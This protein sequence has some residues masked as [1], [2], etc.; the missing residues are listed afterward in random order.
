MGL[1]DIVIR[2]LRD[3]DMPA[4]TEWYVARKWRVPPSPNALPSTAYV[5][6]DS[7]MLL[8][9]VWLYLTNS[10]IAMVDWIAT[11]PASGAKGLISISKILKYIE[12]IID[13]RVTVLMHFT[14]NEKLSK[15]F[16][17]K[18][19]FTGAGKEYISIKTLRGNNG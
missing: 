13:D 11:N 18:C 15:F 2:D 1:T 19:G 5:A 4:V 17:R 10:G 9:V 6:H 12:S 16:G 8:G 3:E 14:S 7:E